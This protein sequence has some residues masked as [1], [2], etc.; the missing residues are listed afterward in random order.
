MLIKS[1]V[2]PAIHVYNVSSSNYIFF[3]KIKFLIAQSLGKKLKLK[4]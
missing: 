2:P 4:F 1:T 3:S